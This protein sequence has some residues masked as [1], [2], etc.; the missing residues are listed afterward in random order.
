M[1]IIVGQVLTY[2]LHRYAL[3][4]PSSPLT[5]RHMSWQHSVSS[6]YSLAANY[7]HPLAYLVRVFLP[8]YIPAILFRFHLL[9]Y[10]LYLALVSL[11]ETFAYSGYNVLPS[12]FI[13]GGI[14]RRQERHLMGDGDGNFGCLGLMDF[15]LGTSLGQDLGEDVRGE[16][17]EE[18]GK[19]QRKSDGKEKKKK[20]SREGKAVEQ[21]K[22]QAK[23]DGEQAVG[24]APDENEG[25][26]EEIARPSS[27]RKRGPRRRA[28]S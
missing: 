11:E 24:G 20:K 8:T 28:R 16:V 19:T 12:A 18:I 22:E 23:E 1:L 2:L 17:E 9:T 3:H 5:K 15:A 21:E 6:P 26:E 27:P 13:L 14:A 10:H 25:E 7:H 4:T